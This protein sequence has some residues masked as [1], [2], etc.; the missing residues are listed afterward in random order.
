LKEVA[1]P[2][3]PQLV[4]ALAADSAP[5]VREDCAWALA[6]IGPGRPE[7]IAAL[8]KASQTDS[9]AFVR[10]LAADHLKRARR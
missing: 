7:V 4:E 3:I 2:A 10:S 9:E 8:E 1:V 5:D 6:E